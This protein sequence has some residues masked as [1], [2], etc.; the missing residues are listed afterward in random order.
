[1]E[2]R[3][4]NDASRLRSRARGPSLY[5]PRAGKAARVGDWDRLDDSSVGGYFSAGGYDDALVDP[6]AASRASRRRAA[7]EG[8]DLGSR[9]ASSRRLFASN[10][11]EADYLAAVYGPSSSLLQ[12]R[13]PAADFGAA[14]ARRAPA[15]RQYIPRSLGETNA[16]RRAYSR[17]AGL[18]QS[19]HADLGDGLGLDRYGGPAH[20]APP[21]TNEDQPATDA[22]VFSGRII[23]PRSRWK[24]KDVPLGLESLSQI[25]FDSDNPLDYAKVFTAWTKVIVPGPPRTYTYESFYRGFLLN[26][27]PEGT[28]SD[29]KRVGRKIKMEELTFRMSVLNAA[30]NYIARNGYTVPEIGIIP[31][32]P[33][34]VP[35]GYYT[36]T[37]GVINPGYL[38]PSTAPF[39]SQAPATAA[40]PNGWCL[41]R[42][43]GGTGAIL[44]SS[45]YV[46]AGL[47]QPAAIGV[48]DYV[49]ITYPDGFGSE[50]ITPGS[51]TGLI[52]PPPGTINPVP[53]NVP[54]T[55][56]AIA[57]GEGTVL[58]NGFNY[59]PPTMDPTSACTPEYSWQTYGRREYNVPLSTGSKR[60]VVPQQVCLQGIAAGYLPTIRILIVY[61][62]QPPH[63]PNA[64]VVPNIS[65]VLAIKYGPNN[66]D[67]AGVSYQLNNTTAA[68]VN[69]N[70]RDRFEIVYDAVHAGKQTF[71]TEIVEEGVTLDRHVIFDGISDTL[72]DITTG[73]LYM[74]LISE[75]PNSDPLPLSENSPLAPVI[76]IPH[77]NFRLYYTDV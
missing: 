59:T 19:Y 34:P 12:P 17:D 42:A 46:P 43:G 4:E 36:D 26:G 14:R 40:A 39:V 10:A 32:P 20:P 44:P 45:E 8:E 75:V 16:S 18:L 11:E 77:G 28:D 48:A 76:Y 7:P 30:V 31:P 61:D 25:E 47:L 23:N 51:I 33:D 74:Y 29:D 49:K 15:G 64:V 2:P 13:N 52:A 50:G 73:A 9:R 38:V 68:T 57:A 37:P 22:E 62:G 27:I 71:S 3:D 56:S 69:L 41:T 58:V 5:V 70:Y 6:D 21:L 63:A 1:M 54:P 24:W 67:P 60:Y 65:D 55:E 35:P 66:V 72:D 53:N